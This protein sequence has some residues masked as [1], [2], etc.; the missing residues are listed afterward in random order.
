MD[1]TPAARAAT[2]AVSG[3]ASARAPRPILR[4]ALA[5]FAVLAA[6]A[7]APYEGVTHEQITFI[8]A[9]QFNACVGVDMPRLTPLEARYIAR[10][11]ADQADRNFWRRLFRWNYY[12]RGGASGRLLWTI[13][14]RM[15]R[16]YADLV[17]HLGE[18]EGLPERFSNLGRVV[19]YLQDATTPA[20]VVPVY[21]GR[22]WRLNVTDRFNAFPVDV[23]GL[24]AA[25]ANDCTAL[26]G[27]DV[28]F[29]QLLANTAERTI[30]AVQEV[31]PGMP[32]GWEAFWEFGH[33]VDAFGQY[34]VA[35]NSFGRR[36][37]FAC[38]TLSDGSPRTCVLLENDPLYLDFARA[39]HLDAVHSTIAAM[40]LLRAP[41]QELLAFLEAR[42]R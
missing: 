8:A 32:V 30:A 16:H 20:H 1:V 38:G 4:R 18:E 7:A 40:A 5:A 26:R 21:T 37:D 6:G 17:D 14:T 42:R 27:A 31:I 2:A 39:R 15:N 22:W 10:A 24:V 19:N 36:T 33:D 9:R 23:E 29:E 3:S 28:S 25:V 34:G 11:N 41:P 12:G 35:G 13:E